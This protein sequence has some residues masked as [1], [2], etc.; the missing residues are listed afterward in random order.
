MSSIP[1]PT[2]DQWKDPRFIEGWKRAR[3]EELEQKARAKAEWQNQKSNYQQRLKRE[4]F[5]PT[6]LGEAR[7]SIQ[8]EYESLTARAQRLEP[9]AKKKVGKSAAQAR[10]QTPVL[11]VN[12]GE[13]IKHPALHR[14]T[15]GKL[16]K[17]KHMYLNGLQKKAQRELACGILGG[18]VECKKSGHRFRTHYECG[19]R[20]CTLCAGKEV[21]KQFARQANRLHA[22]AHRLMKCADPDC[23]QCAKVVRGQLPHWPPPAGVKPRIVCAK[24]DFTLWDDK[25]GMPTPE[26]MRELN[27]FIK[28]FWKAVEDR[29]HIKRTE[30]GVA[31]QDE[32]GCNNSN[33][34][35]HGIYVGPWLPQ[36]KKGKELS[37]LWHEI[38]GNSF[39]LSIKYAKDFGEALYHAIKYPAKFA[40]KSSPERLADLEII[41]HRVRRFHTMREFYSPDIPPPPPPEPRKCP[42]CGSE[43]S[44]PRGWETL[45]VLEQEKNELGK[46]LEDVCE[47]QQEMNRSRCFRA[48]P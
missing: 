9:G 48:P 20:Y 40:E 23:Q 4:P 17:S 25:T 1:M 45:E 15:S 19:N 35:A 5:R 7:E 28:A 43:L 21:R 46:P 3:R 13:W 22:V 10:H 34:H 12:D 27:L 47:V 18:R 11:I 42:K 30:Y 33:R 26:D 37:A 32:L 8:G 16:A 14:A 38:T 41:F 39:I 36:S 2:G 6:P 44:E 24:I 31:Y 29:F